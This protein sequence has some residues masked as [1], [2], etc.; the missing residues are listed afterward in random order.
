MSGS[1]GPAALRIDLLGSVYGIPQSKI[2]QLL[3]RLV[4]VNGITVIDPVLLFLS[5]CHCLLGLDQT[6]RQD[7]K[8]LR[9]LCRVL[10]EHFGEALDNVRCGLATERALINAVRGSRG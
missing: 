2:R 7:E 4:M 5:K 6:D 8:H 1:K 9:I 10:P 3:D